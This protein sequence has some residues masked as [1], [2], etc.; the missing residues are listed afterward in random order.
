MRDKKPNPAA[1]VACVCLLAIGGTSAY[2]AYVGVQTKNLT[3]EEAMQLLRE[4]PGADRAVIELLRRKACGSIAML[5]VKVQ[6]GSAD[7]RTALNSIQDA[8]GR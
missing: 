6:D 1:A 7:A 3:F 8:L 5:K 4:T 2:C